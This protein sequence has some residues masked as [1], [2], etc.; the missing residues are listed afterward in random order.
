MAE[1]PPSNA[2]PV[3]NEHFR[4]RF[5]DLVAWRR[6]IRHF[7][8]DPVDPA[9]VDDLIRLACLAPSVGNSQPWR[10]V[11]VDDP[12]LRVRVRA[13][14]ATANSDAL[15]D[16]D[17]ERAKLYASLKLSG[18]DRAPVQVALFCDGAGAL[19]HGL[20][21]RTMPQ[22]LEHS[23]AGA[24]VILGLAARAKGVGVGYVSILDPERLKAD[25][26]V[27]EAWQFVSYMCIGWP[28]IADSPEPELQR[29]GWQDRKPHGS[30]VYRR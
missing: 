12:A 7:K 9:L 26:E 28:D 15:H 1:A 19:G 5:E 11:M 23:V 17:G 10:F 24:A 21:S 30:F 13:N 2:A 25:L 18:L 29:R 14:F 8:P 22:T 6:D 4:R 16:Y 3:F 27:P 20:G